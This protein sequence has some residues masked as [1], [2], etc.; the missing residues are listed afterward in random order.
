MEDLH[1]S[2]PVG[3][4]RRSVPASA[5]AATS[6]TCALLREDPLAPASE[7]RRRSFWCPVGRNGVATAH[8]GTPRLCAVDVFARWTREPITIQPVAPAVPRTLSESSRR[9]IS[10]ACSEYFPVNQKLAAPPN[11]DERVMENHRLTRVGEDWQNKTRW[12]GADGG[13]LDPE[14]EG[15]GRVSEPSPSSHSWRS[16]RAGQLEVAQSSGSGS[17]TMVTTFLSPPRF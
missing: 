10:N 7:P 17:H 15:G 5:G 9:A 4:R 2:N 13:R 8:R 1:A 14:V 11:G 3:R 12:C 16:P 6:P